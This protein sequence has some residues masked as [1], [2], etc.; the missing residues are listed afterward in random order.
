MMKFAG[1]FW[2]MP[3][4]VILGGLKS[5]LRPSLCSRQ[6]SEY[7]PPPPA[8]YTHTHTR[9]LYQDTSIIV[10]LANLCN[11]CPFFY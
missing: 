5:G 8:P 3:K 4:F 11:S 7:P 2:G 6:M 9:G 10:F 1:I